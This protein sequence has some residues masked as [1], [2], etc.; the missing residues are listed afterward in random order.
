MKIAKLLVLSALMLIGNSA[1]AEIVDGVRQQ[2]KPKTVGFQAE[3]EYYLYNVDAAQFF[4]QGNAWGTQASTST[5]SGLKV[6]F[7]K[8][9]IDGA[10]DGKTYLFNDYRSDAWFYVFFNSVN[11]LYVDL[12]NQ[13][14]VNTGWEVEENG[15]G[16][17]RLSASAT[18]PTNIPNKTQTFTEGLT[19]VEGQYVGLDL[20]T[21]A[22]NT[23][24]APFLAPGEGICL[25]WAFVAAEDYE[26]IVPQLVLYAA[27]VPLKELLDKAKKIGADVAAQEA[28]YLDEK[29]TVEQL[30]KAVEAAKAAIEKKEKELAQ[31]EMGKA[32]ADNPVSATAFITN[33]DFTGNILTG[34]DGDAFGVASAKEN[35]E[36]YNKNYNTYQTLKELPNGVYAVGVNSFYRAGN[37]EPAYN[38]YKANN[39]ASRYAKLYAVIGTDTLTTS[40]VSPFV[41]APTENTGVGSESE[42]KDGDVSYWIPN[43]MEAA[44]YYMHTLGLYSNAVFAAVDDGTLTIGVRKDVTIGGDWTLFDDFSLTYYGN[45]ADAYQKWFDAVIPDLDIY[46]GVELPKN[47]TAKYAE[48]YKAIFAELS[49]KKVSNKA[50]VIAA[51]QSAE[52][53]VDA[54]TLNISLWKQL[55]ALVERAKNVNANSEYDP[56]YTDELYDW[57][58]LE[59]EGLFEEL[60]LTNEELQDLIDEKNAQIEEAIRHPYP[61]TEVTGQYLKNPDF[62][63]NADGWTRE[64]ASGGNVAWGSNCYEAWN[65]ASFDIYQIVENAPKGI[66]QISVQGFYRYG[67]GK[68]EDYAAQQV[69]EVKNAPVY[70][71]MNGN[72]TS[73]TNIYGDPVQIYDPDFYNDP[74]P[75]FLREE[76]DIDGTKHYFPNGMHDAAIAFENDMYTQSAFGVVA[77]EGDVLRL[78]VKGSSNQLGDSWVIWDN[79]KLTYQGFDN[80]DVVKP[81]LESAL[82]TGKQLKEKV[83]AKSAVKGLE[84]TLNDAEAAL[85]ESDG[86]KMFNALSALLN[87]NVAANAS[88]VVFES[89][90]TAVDNLSAAIVTAV[91]GTDVIAEA[92]TLRDDLLAKIDGGEL[93]DAD[94]EELQKEIAAMIKKLNVPEEMANASDANPVDCTSMIVNPDYNNGN[95]DG[96]TIDAGT[97]FNSGLIEC[98]NNNFDEYQVI[99]GLPEGTYT[100]TVQGFYRYGFA[101]GEYAAYT[102]DPTANNYLS[103]YAQVGDNEYA[104]AMPRLASDG[105]EE[106]TSTLVRDG[107]FVAGDDLAA[108]VD[109]QWIW[110]T[111]PEV[112]ADSTAATGVRIANGMIPVATLFNAGK[113]AGTEVTFVVGE[114]GTARIGLKKQEE[115][116]TDGSWCIWD[117]WK[118]TYYGPNST[119]TPTE[120]GI[121]DVADKAAVVKTEFFNV[122]GARVNA[123]AKGIIIVK[124]TLSN[125][126]I[127]VKKVTVK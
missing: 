117:N 85:A 69:P 26:A 4:T 35:A 3:E 68:Y 33:P 51:I 72:Q 42:V 44:E 118:M 48:D 55:E 62:T 19:K 111:D 120:T 27:S 109:W 41:G 65:N 90:M 113:F 34:W 36:H 13:T 22:A 86:V 61:G 75:D 123:A 103:L 106:H 12:G 6:K 119:K 126:A 99:E 30:E 43:N 24:L 2:P 114:E 101:E 124:E 8:Y 16:T 67:R 5:S 57:A 10:W 115:K 93:E 29:S 52:T 127:K 92:T 91:S 89:L 71:Y 87:A 79:F 21:N 17:F 53:A 14:T 59:A 110:M 96:W 125:G 54:L 56:F 7:A 15:G 84:T 58:D 11:D 66:Y 70:I 80:I 116:N 76:I 60:A 112:N 83:M 37:A 122:S 28:V 18:V 94:V 63:G 50:E 25:N 39:E 9:T 77:N 40:I 64:A 102:E 82:N 88:I 121:K 46:T 49:S 74:N 32:T 47:H 1:M 73:F 98:Y 81:L 100:V 97:G 107:K 31:G 23:A 95:N 108:D 105:A 104:A 20:S 45:G 78:G 38:N